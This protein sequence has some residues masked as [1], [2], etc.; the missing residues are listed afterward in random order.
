[1]EL[2]K[3]TSEMLYSTLTNSIMEASRVQASV[4]NIQSQFKLEKIYSLDK[5]NKIKSFEDLVNKLGYDTNNVNVVERI[6]RRKN[7]DIA[8]LKK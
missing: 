2:H 8:T 4:N 5:D 6:I 7:V 1:M 3:Q